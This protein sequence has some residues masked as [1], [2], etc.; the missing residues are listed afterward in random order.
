MRFSFEKV[1]YE[2]G[3]NIVCLI[4]TAA[5][6]VFSLGVLGVPLGAVSALAL[7][8]AM[9]GQQ[10]PSHSVRAKSY[11]A[12]WLVRVAAAC[13]EQM[14]Y[15][16]GAFAWMDAAPGRALPFGVSP[17]HF[18]W[19]VVVFVG[20]V[21]VLAY[22]YT[23][24]KAAAAAEQKEHDE[25]LARADALDR[26]RAERVAAEKEAERR[27][28]IELERIKVEA[29]T[30]QAELSAK[31]QA[32][33]ARVQAEAQ[34]EAAKAQAEV[35]RVQAEAAKAQAEERQKQAAAAAEAARRQAEEQERQQEATRK[36]A[37][38][39]AERRR[40]AEVAKRA[41]NERIEQQAREKEAREKAAI[42]EAARLKAE[43]EQREAEAA[44]ASAR[45]SDGKR[46]LWQSSDHNE[47]ANLIIAAT[48]ALQENPTQKQ[49]A[50]ALGISDRALRDFQNKN[51][52]DETHRAF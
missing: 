10:S 31:A 23:A 49:I 8:A 25:S 20:A 42:A 19:A 46:K 11:A 33:V 5:A 36:R 41:E 2:K 27:A 4:I 24:A 14:A 3:I 40:Q 47:K 26:E 18:A 6:P 32:E 22:G 51:V 34:A 9:Q 17:A 16:M 52:K 28:A 38:D 44:A 29:Q 43:A 37:E 45:A 35:A 39:E 13:L 48:K 1:S 7:L 30:K 50:E 21:D 15:Q 12:V